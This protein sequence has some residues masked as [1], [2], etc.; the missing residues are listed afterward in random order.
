[1]T[2]PSTAA[3]LATGLG[4]PVS[5]VLPQ[6]RQALRTRNSAVL[7][8]PPGAGKTT[9]VPLALLDEPWAVQGRLIVLEPRRLAAR[10]AAKR[11]ADLMGEQVGA[12][13]GYRVRLDSRVS[14]ATRIE[15]VTEGVFTRM[16]LDDPALDGVAG[17][18]FDEF[19]E[20]SL[21][22]DLGLAFALEA[23]GLLR[24]DLRVLAMSATLD[25]AA[26]GRLMGEA[27]V[28][29]SGG[30]TFEVE[31][32]YLGR[33][34]QGALERDTAQTV[35]RALSTEEGGILAFLPGQ[36]E[37]LRVAGLLAERLGDRPVDV[38]PLYGALDVAEQERAIRPAP[39]GRRK[40]VLATSIAQTSLTLDDVQV[41]IDSGLIR[42]PRWDAGRGLVRLATVR[43]SRASIDQRRG[44]AG[45][46]GP[47]V[48][49]RL[50]DEVETRAL[51]AFERPEI[52]EADL[53][54]LALDLAVWGAGS[55]ESLAFLDRPPAPAMAEARRLLADLGAL[56]S[57]GALTPH[58]R[59]MARLPLSP[60][61]AHMVLLAASHGQAQR[62]ARIAVLLGEPTL[63]GRDEDLTHRLE[64]LA[65]DPSSRARAARA[66]ADRW[67]DL[68]ERAAP[69][70]ALDEPLDD[71]GLLA[72]AFPDRIAKA[73]GEEG[74]FLLASGRGVQ[75][76]PLSPLARESWLAVGDLAGGG[77]RDRIRLA[78]RLDLEIYRRARPERFIETV[79]VLETPSGALKAHKIVRVGALMAAE[80]PAQDALPDLVERELLARAV[81]T[82][83]ERLPW[84]DRARRLRARVA[85]LRRGDGSWPDLSD[86]A[87]IAGAVDWLSPLLRGRRH[88]SEVS[89]NELEAAMLGLVPWEKQ[90]ELD[91]LAPTH[92]IAPTG[93]SLAIDYDAEGG[94]RV[95]VRVQELFG[96]DRHPVVGEGTPLTLSLLSPAR[97]EIQVTRDLP[98]FWSGSWSE[99]RKQMRGRYPK[100][101]WPE[102]PKVAPPTTRAKS[103]PS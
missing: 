26:V 63:S 52:L 100:H 29:E 17:V 70:G 91:R 9:L 38:L 79:E 48:C 34:S 73:G 62:A 84:G 102:D 93:S 89:S 25:G 16:I 97:R 44:R 23:Q 30:R 8:A 24:E 96:L 49:W 3:G 32:T 54:R 43:A 65:R 13:V 39:Q 45:R 27:A 61:L 60:R 67:A 4:L 74:V 53:S 75:I 81:R 57:G 2:P 82:R 22:A 1:M 18:I 68:A 94:P 41:V 58:G 99:V 11:M 50:W 64:V 14:A 86:E 98:G 28:I 47:G 92:W 71:G 37:I 5:E 78:A 31:T 7:V 80:G 83:L 87:L 103:K 55:G 101:P 19:H 21:D 76:D 51:P 66:Q 35:M 88:L 46:T 12:T 90:R 59:A 42:S 36:V 69:A 20:R 10:A 33:P 15:V 56:D 72:E 6:L 95:E 40:V 85:F 77:R